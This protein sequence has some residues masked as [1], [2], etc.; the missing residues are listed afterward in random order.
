MTHLFD[1][2]KS[3]YERVQAGI[4][5]FLVLKAPKIKEGDTV[6][7]QYSEETE[8]AFHLDEIHLVVAYVTNGDTIGLK[9]NYCVVAVKGKE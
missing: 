3:E 1:S 2:D 5:S 8:K 9:Q 7:L 4:Q 6:I